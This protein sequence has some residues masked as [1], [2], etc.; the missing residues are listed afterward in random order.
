[1]SNNARYLRGIR[2]KEKD[3]VSGKMKNYGIQVISNTAGQRGKY[4]I[5]NFQKNRL[6]AIKAACDR[7]P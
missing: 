3:V 4:Y 1:M 7:W 5:L 6:D 2:F